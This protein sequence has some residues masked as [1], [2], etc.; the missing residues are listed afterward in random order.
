MT[1]QY[2]LKWPH[3]VAAAILLLAVVA[4]CVPAGKQNNN[5]ETDIGAMPQDG[6]AMPDTDS[7]ETQKMNTVAYYQND[8]GYLVPVMRSIQPVEGIARA[9]LGLM[10]KGVYNDMEAARM[11]LRCVIPENTT[12][13]LDISD[14]VARIDMSREA[15]NSPDAVSEYNMVSA[16]VQTLT[17]FPTVKKVRFLIEGKQ[18]DRL[19][20][21]T[22]I[23]GE[24]TRGHVNLE[25]GDGGQ[26][27]SV[28]TLYFTGDA[29]EMIVPVSRVVYGKGD[30]ETAVMELVKGPSSLSPLNSVIPS[31]CGLKSVCVKDGVAYVDFTREFISI[32]EET[33]GGRLALR[34]L[35]LTCMQFDGV[36]SVRVLVEG[37]EYDTGKGTLS[38]P[39]F[40]NHSDDI[41]D[42]FIRS[43]TEE[44]FEFE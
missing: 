8:N 2:R 42:A 26:D 6:Y 27:G 40:V 17:D 18:T 32:A 25:S 4:M 11:G 13:D 20:F 23:G 9:T 1:N 14:G 12:F 41:Q 22:G 38:Q 10:V 24:F 39:T 3:L 16:I 19:P 30:I 28:V 33:D 21:G 31:G 35:V 37:E 7:G 43:K 44:I 29:P 34:A 15:L 5:G 36:N